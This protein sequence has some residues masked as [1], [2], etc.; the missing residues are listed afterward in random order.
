MRNDARAASLRF[1]YVMAPFFATHTRAR[2]GGGGVGARVR[3]AAAAS[4]AIARSLALTCD[5]EAIADDDAPIT[6][7]YV[8]DLRTSVGDAHVRDDARVTSLRVACVMAPLNI[9]HERVRRGGGGVGA[10]SLALACDGGGH[11]G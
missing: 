2:V 10:R 1:D 6:D 7:V 4:L 9:T 11:R 3:A 5:D 8:Y